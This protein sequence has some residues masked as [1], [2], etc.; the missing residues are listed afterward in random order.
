MEEALERLPR[1]LDDA[2]AETLQ[3]IQKQPDGQDTLG[4][5][6]LMWIAHARRPLLVTELSE[7]LAIKWSTSSLKT[8]FR[9]SQKKMVDCCMGLVTVDENSSIIRLVHFSVQ[10]YLHKYHDGVF[11]EG[12][13]T[14]AEGCIIYLFFEPFALGPRRDEV[15]I[16]D[17]ISRNIFAEY[18]AHYWGYHVRSANSEE[19]DQLA[20]SFLRAENHRQ[21]SFQV[22]Q[23]TTNRREEYWNIDEARSCNGL[24]LS[25]MFGLED[26]GKQLLDADE[27]GVDDITK[28]GTTAL[29]KAAAGGHKTFTQMLLTM[30]VDLTKENWYGTALHCAAEAGM[31]VTMVELLGSG[32]DVDIRDRRGRT[33][34]HCATVSGHANAMQSLLEH[35]ANVNAVCNKNYTSLQYAVIWEQPLEVLRTLLL[36]DANT[37]AR[38]SH[39]ATPL[40]NAAMK[41]SKETALLLLGYKADVDA[42]DV[43]CATPLHYAAERNHAS[44]IQHLLDHGAEIDAKTQD[45]ATAL[46]LAAENGG[47]EAVTSLLS[48]G[49]NVE[50]G[51]EERLTPLDVAIRKN[52]KGVARLLLAAGASLEKDDGPT[53]RIEADS[54]ESSAPL[55]SR[56]QAAKSPSYELDLCKV[57]AD[58]KAKIKTSQRSRQA[59]VWCRVSLSK[60]LIVW[61]AQS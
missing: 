41:N 32:L 57:E 54:K 28:M 5:E 11:V 16:M 24:H 6:T 43:H 22:L 8:R 34:L 39:N 55:P 23:Y 20:L 4:M 53:P 1:A 19:V 14:V 2:F 30:Q 60:K 59:C 17:L 61:T 9:P 52:H 10:E 12:E 31:V 18:A 56:I 50:I 37:E 51:N 44:I 7:A 21:C 40:H 27:V 15:E 46:Y 33:S 35:G 38:S 3:R 48:D 45:G 42:K 47:E 49:A 26:L 25:A 58:I 13:R 29:I 36:N